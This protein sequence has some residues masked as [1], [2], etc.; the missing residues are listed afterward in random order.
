M[1]H[2]PHYPAPWTIDNADNMGDGY[3]GLTHKNHSSF[4][5][6]VVYMS[7]TKPDDPKNNVLRANS[8]LIAASPD[9]LAA[10]KAQHEAIDRLFAMLI[11]LDHGFLPS[12]SGQPW[13]AINQGNEAIALAEEDT[14]P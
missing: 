1:K 7:H 2:A 8:Q 11:N 14:L 13:S 3:V 5:E 12:K 9:L 6:V 10:C 4:A